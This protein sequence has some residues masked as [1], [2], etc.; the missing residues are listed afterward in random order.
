M[1]L[2][3]DNEIMDVLTGCKYL[4]N[5]IINKNMAGISTAPTC[6]N[7]SD[8]LGEGICVWPLRSGNSGGWM[9]EHLTQSF[10]LF[11]LGRALI[12]GY[13]IF[14]WRKGQISA[15]QSTSDH[16]SQLSP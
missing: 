14:S 4:T 5:N 2:N 8:R 13:L 10:V 7:V 15:T 11:G 6:S 16:F 12:G 3:G 1:L 9:F